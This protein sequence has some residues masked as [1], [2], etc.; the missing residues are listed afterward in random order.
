MTQTSSPPEYKRIALPVGNRGK[1]G[2]LPEFV[3]ISFTK[4][5]YQEM[6][7]QAAAVEAAGK[8]RAPETVE[9]SSYPDVRYYYANKEPEIVETLI[10][11][12][13]ENG[14]VRLGVMHKHEPSLGSVYF[15]HTMQWLLT[16]WR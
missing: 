7:A 2:M 4:E 11:L 13:L 15:S 1:I 8:E 10:Y 6:S 14:D 16:N 3:V 9:F 5:Q 12:T